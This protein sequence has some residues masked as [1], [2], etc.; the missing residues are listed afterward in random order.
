MKPPEHNL[1]DSATG[2]DVRGYYKTLGIHLA[3]WSQHEAAVSC[4]ADPEAHRHGDR[5]PS[6]SVNLEH[7]AWHCHGC[8]ASGGAYDAAKE[9]GYTPRAAID[10]MVRHGLVERRSRHR[11]ARRRVLPPP[12]IATVPQPGRRELAVTE[13]DVRHWQLAL[14][15]QPALIARLTRQRAWLYSTMWELGLGY[16]CGRITI[17]VRQPD[18]KLVGLLRYQPW[19][20]PGQPKMLATAGSRRVL[21][22]HPSTERSREL[23]LVEGEPDM[24]AARSRG[25]P[26]I[27]LPGADAWQSDWAQL[28]TGRD[29][30]I[31]MDADPEGRRA[32]ERIAHD[33][34]NHAQATVLDL[35]PERN[36]GYD[37]TDWVLDGTR[38]VPRDEDESVGA[39]LAGRQISAAR[40]PDRRPMR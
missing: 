32:A 37:L 19:P 7:G 1:P 38:S 30:T 20:P 33:L 39:I 18:H 10:L 14:T 31:V 25:L 27:A 4:F 22:P 34:H 11:S 3:D 16:D 35:A 21:L 2:A 6:C 24:I 13:S 12:G 9:R 17:P 23:L 29:V 36:D 26:A 40:P 15:E 8:G 5:K 28:F